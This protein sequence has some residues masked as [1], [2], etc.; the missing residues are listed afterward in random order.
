VTKGLRKDKMSTNTTTV[1]IKSH[2]GATVKSMHAAITDPKMQP[3][4]I[5]DADIVI[6]Y[7]GINNISNADKPTDICE[8][9]NNLTHAIQ[10][11]NSKAKV[12]SSTKEK[13]PF[14]Y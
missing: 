9:F 13:R 4:T 10:G 11:I 2:R 12:I 6:I 14:V 8:E 3:K 1:D 7:A 5:T